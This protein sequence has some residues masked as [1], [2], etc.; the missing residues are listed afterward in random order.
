VI[1]SVLTESDELRCQAL[2]SN[3]SGW[4]QVT[5]FPGSAEYR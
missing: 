5:S 4:S 2:E 1:E 3:T